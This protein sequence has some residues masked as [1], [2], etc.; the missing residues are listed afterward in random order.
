VLNL[1]FS[2]IVAYL[3]SYPVE[4][5]IPL[6]DAS[7]RLLDP[8]A[9]D[10]YGNTL[11]LPTYLPSHCG[12]NLNASSDTAFKLSVNNTPSSLFTGRVME[13]YLHGRTIACAIRQRHST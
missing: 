12:G 1:Q 7:E 13:S 10:L 2:S 11:T 6:F 8:S 5:S 9:L 3:G 4:S